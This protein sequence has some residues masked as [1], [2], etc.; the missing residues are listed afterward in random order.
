MSVI[1]LNIPVQTKKSNNFVFYTH[2]EYERLYGWKKQHDAD[3]LFAGQRTHKQ[4]AR[5]LSFLEQFV[6]KLTNGEKLVLKYLL[7]LA[8]AAKK[9]KKPLQIKNQ[10]IANEVGCSVWLVKQA[11]KKFVAAKIFAK[12]Q[13]N[14]YAV[15]I[16]TCLIDKKSRGILYNLC[17]DTTP[18]ILKIKEPKKALKK[19]S[20]QLYRESVKAAFLGYPHIHNSPTTDKINLI[21]IFKDFIKFNISNTLIS[22]INP[23]KFK[24]FTFS[25]KNTYKLFSFKYLNYPSVSLA[26]KSTFFHQANFSGKSTLISKTNYQQASFSGK[27]TFTN[28]TNSSID[29]KRKI[30]YNKNINNGLNSIQMDKATFQQEVL[31]RLNPDYVEVL[32]QQFK[33]EEKNKQESTKT[34]DLGLRV[35]LIDE[36]KKTYP[37]VTLIECDYNQEVFLTKNNERLLAIRNKIKELYSIHGIR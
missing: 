4:Q 33:L 6:A 19:T 21:Y 5:S 24:P 11:T 10:S 27:N 9:N 1:N 37:E 28:E 31:R 2:R 7:C 30:F 13:S 8:L 35:K 26:G 23:I 36:A 20:F 22:K 17:N 14:K 29:K 32:K 12:Q 3:K 15:N 18:H 25:I 34:N 16:Y